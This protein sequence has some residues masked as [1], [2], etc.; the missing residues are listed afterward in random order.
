LGNLRGGPGRAYNAL[1]PSYGAST[2]LHRQAFDDLTIL[3]D[4][5]L[6]AS[7]EVGVY[8]TRRH[9]APPLSS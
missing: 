4:P 1:D 6:Q 7:L 3:L 9:S 5:L 8:A 2:S